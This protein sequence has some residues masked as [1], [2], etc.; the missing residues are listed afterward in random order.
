MATGGG[1]QVV[2]NLVMD[3]ETFERNARRLAGADPGPVDDTL[4]PALDH[5]DPEDPDPSPD[6]FAPPTAG[7]TDTGVGYRCSTLDGHLVDAR[8]AVAEA[9]SARSGGS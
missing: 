6:D 3:M 9:R 1:S 5:L 2:T 7:A 8:S 4:D